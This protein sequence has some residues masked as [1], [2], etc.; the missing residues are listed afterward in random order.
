M[1]T[2]LERSE[3]KVERTGVAWRLERRGVQ[4]NGGMERERERGTEESGGSGQGA[5]RG[6]RIQE[7]G[8]MRKEG[9]VR[10]ER[11]DGHASFETYVSCVCIWVRG[12]VVFGYL[13]GF[14]R[15]LQESR[16]HLAQT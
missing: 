16:Q 12:V 10:E 6:E 3:R 2:L 1:S 11:D 5:E 15:F 8:E 13:L 7:R 9:E 4:G 14:L